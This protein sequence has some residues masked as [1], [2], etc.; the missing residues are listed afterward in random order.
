MKEEV[1]E[2]GNAGINVATIHRIK[3]FFRCKRQ[4]YNNEGQW[5]YHKVNNWQN[6]RFAVLE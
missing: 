6:K 1:Q 5:E 3:G 4:Q 2:R